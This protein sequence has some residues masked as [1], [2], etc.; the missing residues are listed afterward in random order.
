M[1]DGMLFAV[2]LYK[3][4]FVDKASRLVEKLIEYRMLDLQLERISDIGGTEPEQRPA[5]R[6]TRPPPV[7]GKIEVRNLSFR[8]SEGEPMVFENVSFSV[9]AG[10]YVAITG[11]SGGGKTTLLKIM[12]GLLPPTSGE[13]RVDG[14]PI[15]TLGG[16]TL[17]D[18]VGV[19]MQ[20]DQL[21]CGSI[22]DNIC[23]FPYSLDHE[24]MQL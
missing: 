1:T 23:L 22:A 3:Q 18:S 21:L 5:R 19:V 24:H 12:L 13:V 8:Y 7:N 2:V 11:P 10:E 15:R 6:D 4:Q 9:E 16:A 20:D 14:L 17:R